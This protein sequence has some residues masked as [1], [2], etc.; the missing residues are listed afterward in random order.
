MPVSETTRSFTSGYGPS[1]FTSYLD[2][3][4][5]HRR[6]NARL[7][8]EVVR[9]SRKVI[10][11]TR[12]QSDVRVLDLGCGGRGGIVLPLHTLGVSATGIDYDLVSPRLSPSSWWALARRNGTERA[13][14]TIGRQVLFD[15]S[16]YKHMRRLLGRELRWDGLDVRTMDARELQFDD[17]S[18][19]FIF[20]TAV[21]EHIS[22]VEA[23]TAEMRRVLC[24]GGKAYIRVHLFP[25]PS[26]GHAL[27][28]ADADENS[29]PN[30][31]VPP[32]DHLRERQF[33]PHVYLNQMRSDE[34]LTIFRQH[35]NILHETYRT[36]GQALL[37]PEIRAELADWSEE[38]LTRRNLEVLL[39]T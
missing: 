24:N 31:P 29:P 2:V 1:A 18:F 17:N 20:S 33:P 36:E 32:W 34:F 38:D 15:R 9:H 25:S 10:E 30:T 27:D 6:G 35:F 39:S 37:T 14:K 3:F 16:Y 21:F 23:A 7:A 28:W 26:G 11:L 4:R 5:Y 22:D 8:S 19:S 13:I 12:D